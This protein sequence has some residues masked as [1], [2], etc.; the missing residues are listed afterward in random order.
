MSLDGFTVVSAFLAA[1]EVALGGV[2]VALGIREARARADAG[3]AAPRRPL[4]P[5][6]AAALAATAVVSIPVGWLLL[7]SWIPRWPGV[8]CV[9]GVRRIGEGTVGAS[10]F[11][12]DLAAALDFTRLLVLF[13]AGAWLVLRRSAAVGAPRRAAIA[14][15]ILGAVALV[16]GAA[17][18]GFAVLPREEV[19]LEAGCCTVPQRGDERLA[20]GPGGGGDG[21]PAALIG[22]AAL[23]G[24]GALAARGRPGTGLLPLGVLALLAAAS[25]PLAARFL[26]EVAAPAVLRSPVP[27]LLLVRPRTRAGDGG[28]GA[29]GGGGGLLRGLGVPRAVGRRAAGGAPAPRRGV[30]RF[31]RARGDGDRDSVPPVTRGAARAALFVAGVAAVAVLPIL[32]RAW[33]SG[34][35]PRCALDGVVLDASRRVRVVDADGADRLLCCIA[36]GDRWLAAAGGA[37]PPRA[38]FVADEATGVEVRAEEAWFVRSRVP[39]FPVCACFVHAF[40][41][42]TD[43]RLHAEAFGGVVLEGNARPLQGA[44][45]TEGGRR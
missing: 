41:R 20:A 16:D 27:P 32:G 10:R 23:L 34:G 22:V 19:H 39:A 2:A 44:Q 12:P 4:L 45:G 11:L 38:A 36:C 6:V 33:R 13:A 37:G 21:L 43:A 30:L 17:S 14:A 26:A 28:G 29:A 18:F 5:L 9:A 35:E 1:V 24:A 42:E 8:M 3:G 40:A 25:L 15:A 31:P 7:E